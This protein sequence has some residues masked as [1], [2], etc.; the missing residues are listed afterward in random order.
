VPKLA[1]HQPLISV[2]DRRAYLGRLLLVAALGA[3]A[4]AWAP[5]SARAA[6][7]PGRPT[8]GRQLPFSV[9]VAALQRR[10]HPTSRSR[11][12]SNVRLGAFAGQAAQAAASARAAGLYRFGATRSLLA[13]ARTSNGELRPRTSLVVNS[14]TGQRL[15][16]C[17]GPARVYELLSPPEGAT[18]H[19]SSL[20]HG[21][22]GLRRPHRRRI[23][24]RSGPAG[25][26]G[27][28]GVE[29]EGVGDDQRV[30][31]RAR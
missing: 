23:S 9:A 18:D 21:R 19:G 15:E 20:G 28:P 2:A 25:R 26:S 27:P 29:S 22:N 16:S 10:L 12:L 11:F 14:T 17:Y 1:R 3:L 5:D 8:T 24:T 13:G 30:G 4:A 6:A 31:R 7:S